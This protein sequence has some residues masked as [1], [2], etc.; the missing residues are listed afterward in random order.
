MSDGTAP[1][2]TKNTLGL[3]TIDWTKQNEP[4]EKSPEILAMEQA[5]RDVILAK[6]KAKKEKAAR[7]KARS[8]SP[9][10]K[11]K[12]SASPP[13]ARKKTD[14]EAA[15]Q[16]AEEARI[17]A[18]AAIAAERRKLEADE[19]ARLQAE[20]AKLAEEDAA[21]AER[22]RLRKLQK[23]Q[24][25][26]A[27]EAERLRLQTIQEE[28][29][30]LRRA[31]EEAEAQRR[32][33]EEEAAFRLAAEEEARKRRA[34]LEAAAAAPPPVQPRQKR[35]A[36]FFPLT[37]DN[38]GLEK[39]VRKYN[40]DVPFDWEKPEWTM[41]FGNLRHTTT[42]SKTYGWEKPEWVLRNVLR[43]TPQGD[44]IHDGHSLERPVHLLR[45][46]ASFADLR[47]EWAKP[48]WTKRF[49]LLR[50]TNHTRRTTDNMTIGTCSTIGD[51]SVNFD[52][53][54]ASLAHVDFNGSQSIVTWEKP[55]WAKAHGLKATEAGA[56]ARQGIN[57][58][59]PITDINNFLNRSLNRQEHGMMQDQSLGNNNYHVTNNNEAS[60]N[61]SFHNASLRDLAWE[62]PSWASNPGLK[63]TSRG[64]TLQKN[65]NLAKAISRQ[66]SME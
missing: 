64:E 60:M 23:E 61:I 45:R 4:E 6:K 25:A 27:V 33:E 43:K 49:K 39:A 31:A 24:A 62:K 21:E 19:E 3:L 57:L 15:L 52:D 50:S 2:Q 46:R 9:T 7:K 11:N 48:E 12:K 20:A 16:A 47:S 55:S 53:S 8:Q 5:A 17:K 10:T 37:K 63:R 29:E 13:R 38:S 34:A 14:E 22:Q 44:F 59:L 51:D 56:A 65:G 36:S 1:F 66:K 28:E 30:A 32:A 54:I 40:N 35:R 58:A 26:A 42:I 41:D 18:E